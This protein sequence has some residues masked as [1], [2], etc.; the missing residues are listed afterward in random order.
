M[1]A[2]QTYYKEVRKAAI[3]GLLTT[4]NLSGK[5]RRRLLRSTEV[6]LEIEKSQPKDEAVR[7]AVRF[8]RAPIASLGKWHRRV[9]RRLGVIARGLDAAIEA[10][11]VKLVDVLQVKKD[12]FALLEKQLREAIVTRNKNSDKTYR[13]ESGQLAGGPI[14]WKW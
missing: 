6:P 3:N 4:K 10:G 12:R 13:M 1:N 2:N 8:S 9:N 5:L 11:M 14:N 7:L